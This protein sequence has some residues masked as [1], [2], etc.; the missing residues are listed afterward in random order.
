MPEHAISAMVIASIDIS[1]LM[2]EAYAA[3]TLK[4]SDAVKLQF[5]MLERVW[6]SSYCRRLKSRKVGRN[7]GMK[8]GTA[9]VGYTVG[10][11]VVGANV[12]GIKNS[13]GE[14]VGESVISTVK[15]AGEVGSSVGILVNN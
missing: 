2:D 5:V 10:K 15:I 11:V 1:T 6:F 12:V 13:V 14:L 7:V 3:L 8:V 4:R 9:V